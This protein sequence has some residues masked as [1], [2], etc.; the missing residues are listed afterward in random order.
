MQAQKADGIIPNEFTKKDVFMSFFN[1]AEPETVEVI[2]SDDSNYVEVTVM[3]KIMSRP[4]TYYIVISLGNPIYKFWCGVEI[5]SCLL[6]SYMY[7]YCAVFKNDIA[8]GA[9]GTTR[10]GDMVY[11]FESIFFISII[12]KFFLEYKVDD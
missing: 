9:P 2:D 1:G 11:I 7:A 10:L 12:L 6:S 3:D 8:H 4:L 5:L